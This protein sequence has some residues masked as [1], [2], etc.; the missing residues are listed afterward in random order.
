MSIHCR[1]PLFNTDPIGGN[2]GIGAADA[3]AALD[4]RVDERGGRQAQRR[5]VIVI[6]IVPGL[7]VVV[8][9]L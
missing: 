1:K 3:G 7:E 2:D 8:I 9:T 6:V 4:V 5:E